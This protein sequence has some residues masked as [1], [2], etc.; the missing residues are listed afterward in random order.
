MEEKFELLQFIKIIK[1]RRIII[2]LGTL[3]CLFL[4][5]VATDYTSPVYESSVQMM[6][7]Q[8]QVTSQTQPLIES[9]QA[10]LLSERLTATFSQMLASRTLAERVIEK[11]DLAL[12]P[13]NLQK[14]IR[15]E[16]V[17]ETQLIRFTITDANPNFTKKLADTYASEFVK[18]TDEVIPSSAL[19]N[20]RVV[21][22]AAVPRLPVWPKPLSNLI[23]AFLIGLVLSTGFAFILSML[24]VTIKETED[25][26][27]LVSLPSL[28][29]IPISKNPLLLG[30]HN[31]I[32]AEAYR[33]L[34]TN[35]QYI[36][37]DQSIKSLI[38]SSPSLNEGKTTISFN[39]ATVF[40]QAGYNV[41]LVDGDLRSPRLGRL[42]NESDERGLSNVLV[43]AVEVESAIQKASEDRLYY[44]KSGPTP[45]NPADLLGSERMT[46]LLGKLEEDFN[47]V[48]IDCP[49]IL[50]VAD[51]PIVAVKADAVLLVS[52]F[53]KTKKGELVSAKDALNKVGAR[54]IGF[55]VNGVEA[56]SR[57]KFDYYYRKSHVKQKAA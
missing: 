16:A 24:D 6:V 48:I 56:T 9:Y 46:E 21:D 53:G 15:A 39:L 45:P 8:G 40:A 35:L 10:T 26:E 34:R 49:P 29:Q 38:V 18:M 11:L 52:S 36:N 37:F 14:R 12:A 19:I 17:K 33:S 28:G 22:Q 1:E 20:V 23:Q 31:P 43:S 42:F 27:K 50:A 54:I 41:L 3:I 2:I 25:V 44:M 57:R 51:T 47:L 4:A 5:K 55:V 13:E 7:S 30:N 32:V